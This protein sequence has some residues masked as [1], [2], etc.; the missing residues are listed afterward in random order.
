MRFCC[1]VKLTSTKRGTAGD[2]SVWWSSDWRI[3][4]LAAAEN[5]NFQFQPL[6]NGKF[7]QLVELSLTL[8]QTGNSLGFSHL[9]STKNK[10]FFCIPASKRS[11]P[12]QPA[13]AASQPASAASKP[14]Q[15]AQPASQR[16]QPASQPA[17]PAS[18]RSQPASQLAS[19]ASQY[20][21]IYIPHSTPPPPQN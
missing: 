18:Q 6:P 16:S 10:Q 4:L 21:Y 12:A 19:A 5:C 2:F 17:Q 14:A 20:I 7:P 9:S 11:Q 8:H 1:R 3:P 13:S 15:P